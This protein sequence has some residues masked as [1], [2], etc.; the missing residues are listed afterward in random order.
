MSSTK[1]EQIVAL[2]YEWE[3]TLYRLLNDDKNSP[4]LLVLIREASETIR[5]NA[6]RVGE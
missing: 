5:R 1:R 6:W 2:T 3:K 4:T